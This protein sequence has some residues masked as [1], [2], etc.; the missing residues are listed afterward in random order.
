MFGTRGLTAIEYAAV[1]LDNSYKS[2]DISSNNG[3]TPLRTRKR[4]QNSAVTFPSKL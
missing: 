4:K 2:K 3:K 1:Q